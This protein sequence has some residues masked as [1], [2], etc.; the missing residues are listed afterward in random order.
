VSLFLG[1]DPTTRQL[2]AS[3]IADSNG[4]WRATVV[5][6]LADGL[7]TNLVAEATAVDDVTRATSSLPRLMIDTV[8]PRVT[9]V[10]LA[11]LSGRVSV[12][13]QDDRSGLDQARFAE[14]ASYS[15]T[16]RSVLGP[17]RNGPFLIT[18]VTMSPPGAPTEAQVVNLAINNGRRIRGG[19]FTFTVHSGG[20]EDLAGNALDGEFTGSFPS[21]NSQPG[22][23]FAARLRS[24]LRVVGTPTPVGTG[25]SQLPGA[26]A[27]RR[28]ANPLR[29]AAVRKN[30]ANA[31]PT[32]PELLARLANRPQALIAAATK[33][34]GR[35]VGR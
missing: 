33:A 30:A 21:G 25:V 1:T 29:G 23:D 20:I 12:T 27:H 5:I 31:H 34:L 3:A 11:R 9:N 35:R 26:L 16:G 24:V 7:Y 15:F 17:R 6:P 18:G 14:R 19:T 2:I 8:G 13:L 28:S 22:G 10:T 32:G 4:V